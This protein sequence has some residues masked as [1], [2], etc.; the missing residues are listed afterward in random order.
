[1]KSDKIYE[2]L[3]AFEEFESLKQSSD[4]LEF[5]DWLKSNSFN[6]STSK[7]ESEDNNN[8]E[9]IFLMSRFY[10]YCKHYYK[11]L[12]KDLSIKT[13]DEF[14]ILNF[15]ST[16][17]LPTKTEI[18]ENS[19]IDLPVGTKM[20]KRLIELGLITEF[21]D[22]NDKRIRRI[23]ITDKGIEEKN[24]VLE[25]LNAV[26]NFALGKLDKKSKNQLLKSLKY[27]DSYHNV[28]YKESTFEL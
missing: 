23:E 7:I 19:V 8:T 17:N 22:E 6:N 27:L 1:M 2:I 21:A 5:A 28:N 12:W 14:W 15:I 18:Y 9:I 20:I 13:I 16:A 4:L 25:R 11:Q 3:T 24:A 26:S 10:R